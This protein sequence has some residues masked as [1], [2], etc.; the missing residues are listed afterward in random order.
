MK[1]QPLFATALAVP[2]LAA[3]CAFV[4]PSYWLALVTYSGMSALVCI[5]LVMMTGYSGITSFGQAAF[6]GLGAYTTA[7]VTTRVGFSPW[8]GLAAGIL[9]TIVAASVIGWVTVRLSGHY[10]VIGTFAWSI[11]LYYVFAN[12]EILGGYNGLGGVT[13]L[14]D[15]NRKAFNALVW[16][17]VAL[18]LIA[19]IRVLD[20]R[21]GRAMR[22]APSKSMAEAFGIDT[23]RAKFDVFVFGAI[24]A[25]VAGWLQAHYLHFVN[26]GPFHLNASVEYLFMTII[27]GVGSLL[28]ALAGSLVV[29]VTKSFLQ[30]AVPALFGVTANHETVVF[31][32][33]VLV[34]LHGAPRGVTSLLPSSFALVPR[35][36][37]N[38]A[39]RLQPRGKPNV[40]CL[41]LSVCD[42]SKSFG[43][44]RAL[45]GV[46]FDLRAGEIV[47]LVGP[48]GAGKSTLF[49]VITGLS[50][51][52]SGS[53]HLMDKPVSAMR[54]RH[55]AA[56]GISRTFQ[57]AHLR[58]EMTVLENVAIGAHAR[59]R[60]GVA[61]ALFG[62]DGAE[63]A[64]ILGEARACL[65]GL[66]LLDEANV[67]A[68]TL[69]LGKRRLVEVAR[70]L[71]SDPLVMLLDEPAAGLGYQEKVDLA[72]AIRAMRDLGMAMLVVEHDLDFV[73]DIA[74]RVIVLDFGI[75]IA[76]GAPADIVRDPRVVEAY[77][78]RR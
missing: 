3:A 53:V 50:S 23:A 47:A 59:S 5:G 28:G 54:A 14:F 55:F 49:N 76:E 19:A 11:S 37:G 22:A 66:G 78:G 10:L 12:V 31:G 15:G 44:V 36:S 2:A 43:G 25:S 68:G 48:N 9:I 1:A 6:A 32:L 65:A 40:G 26:P 70:A 73:A 74:Q 4:V 60:G 63:E 52:M 38:A 18:A 17:L 29:T 16:L 20:S 75:K 72:A 58:P 42:V 57:H 71:A 69:P 39:K 35:R 34:L 27:G 77:L 46:S 33:L 56:R 64:L 61:G 8:L 51:G 67:L 45:D 30:V 21:A 7:L 13:A 24:L 62:F 41:V